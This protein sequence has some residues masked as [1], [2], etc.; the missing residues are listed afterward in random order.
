MVVPNLISLVFHFVGNQLQETDFI[1][2][3]KLSIAKNGIAIIGNIRYSF[4]PHI[5]DSI[6]KN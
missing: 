1:L 4:P 6:K 3:A 2:Y 5:G